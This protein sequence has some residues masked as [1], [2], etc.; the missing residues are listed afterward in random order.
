MVRARG[1]VRN[2]MATVTIKNHRGQPVMSA[3][4]QKQTCAVQCPLMTQSGHARTDQSIMGIFGSARS[5]CVA[6]PPEAHSTMK[7]GLL[8]VHCSQ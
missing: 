6:A 8:D 3:L 5:L 7:Y 2:R 1:R 4:G